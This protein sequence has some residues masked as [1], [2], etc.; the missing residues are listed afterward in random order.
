MIDLSDKV[1]TLC[2]MN[3]MKEI[4]L[5]DYAEFL[6]HLEPL[7]WFQKDNN[8]LPGE[9]KFGTFAINFLN[10]MRIPTKQAAAIFKLFRQIRSS[11]PLVLAV[12]TCGDWVLLVRTTGRNFL[13]MPGGKSMPKE[14]ALAATVREAK[15]ET[16]LDLDP[17]KAIRIETHSI[18]LPKCNREFYAFHWEL[19]NMVTIVPPNPYEIVHCEWAMKNDVKQKV[20]GAPGAAYIADVLF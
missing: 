5:K 7:Y 10:K 18:Y 14:S 12:I 11:L 3:T 4:M 6:F 9:W 15:E 20:A 8:Q 2:E 17:S 16:G 13:E 19:P 1:N